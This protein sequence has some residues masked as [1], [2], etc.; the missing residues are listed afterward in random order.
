[1][2]CSRARFREKMLSSRYCWPSFEDGG[3]G[4]GDGGGFRDGRGAGQFF[5]PCATARSPTCTLH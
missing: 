3:G 2:K 4:G 5:E 1:M